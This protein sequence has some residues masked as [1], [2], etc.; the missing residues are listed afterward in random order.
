M[1][2]NNHNSRNIRSKQS[3]QVDDDDLVTR[4]ANQPAK[5]GMSHGCRFGHSLP[6]GLPIA[7]IDGPVAVMAA[8]MDTR[9]PVTGSR[10][11]RIFHQSVA[12]TNCQLERSFGLLETIWV[13][14]TLWVSGARTDHLSV[15]H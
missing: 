3:G 8:A 13:H 14:A 11:T 15:H 2:A 9:H 12:Q 4:Y 6:L 10:T 7:I 5:E 1:I